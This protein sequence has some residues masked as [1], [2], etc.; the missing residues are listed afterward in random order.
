MKHKNLDV[1]GMIAEAS[2]IEEILCL[3]TLITGEI[4]PAD[5]TI[6]D[7]K[8]NFQSIDESC[9]NC[10]LVNRCLACIINQ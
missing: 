9:E 4:L 5:S 6:Y 2:D 1:M 10:P 8:A 3:A 7:S